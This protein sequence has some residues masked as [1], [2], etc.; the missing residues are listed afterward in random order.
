MMNISIN[1]ED[2]HLNIEKTYWIIDALYLN[3]IAKQDLSDVKD[4]SQF[5]RQKIFMYNLNP[6]AYYKPKDKIFSVKKIKQLEYSV[7][8]KNNMEDVFST[9]TGLVLFINEN[10]IYT[11]LKYYNY[12]NLVDSMI[13]IINYEYWESIVNK[14]EQDDIALIMANDNNNFEF[15]GSGLYRVI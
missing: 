9:D 1:S 13:D 15:V 12:D 11:L 10:I 8:D 4:I 7:I 14:F 2:I 3:D 6:F 5:V